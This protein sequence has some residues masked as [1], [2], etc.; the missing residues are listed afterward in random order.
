M[1]NSGTYRIRW[2]G[3]IQIAGTATDYFQSSCQRVLKALEVAEREDR[4]R[5]RESWREPK[6]PIPELIFPM[7]LRYERM[8]TGHY[9]PVGG[10][11]K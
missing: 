6:K 5:Q 8:F 2:T 4:V 3:F 10:P 1:A 9:F 7:I 11:K